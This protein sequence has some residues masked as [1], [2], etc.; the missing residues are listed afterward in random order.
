MSAPNI[1]T[2]LD[3]WATSLLKH[4][5]HPPFADHKDLYNTIDNIP[6]GG[7]NWQTFGVQYSGDKPAEPDVPPW[8]NE[9]FDVWY[10][11]PREVVRNI[12][13]NPDYANE[14]DYRPF[15]EFSVD[16]NERRFQDFMSAN[17]AW[18][19]AVRPYIK[20]TSSSFE[21]FLSGYHCH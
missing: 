9:R 12:L 6:I 20:L 5:D 15:R 16:K 8:M 4:D 19:Q 11:D 14:F 10:C 21:S 17:W 3:L 18:H 2:L 13:A 1:N 7:V